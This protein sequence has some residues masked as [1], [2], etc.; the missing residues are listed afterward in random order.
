MLAGRFRLCDVDE[1]NEGSLCLA[2]GLEGGQELR[3]LDDK[4]MGK[5]YLV[6]A[7]DRR[8]VPGFD[9]VGIESLSREFTVE[10]LRALIQDRRD[11]VRAFLLDKSAV[12][13]TPHPKGGARSSGPPGSIPRPA[14]RGLQR[15][16]SAVSTL[17][18]ARSSW[19]PSR[20]SLGAASPSR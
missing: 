14:V 20:K 19:P 8:A 9:T 10:R 2:F 17:P 1:R 16:I 5:V 18:S 11:Q 6:S 12:A 13:A 7:G 3:Y 4:Q 15:R